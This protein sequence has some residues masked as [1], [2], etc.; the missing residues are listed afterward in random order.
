MQHANVNANVDADADADA[1]VCLNILKY[2]I[3]EKKVQSPL[4][5]LGM[6]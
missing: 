4:C 3:K 1:D 6:P 5:S 2:Y